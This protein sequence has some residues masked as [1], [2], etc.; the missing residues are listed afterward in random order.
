MEWILGEAK[1]KPLGIVIGVLIALFLMWKYRAIFAPIPESPEE[2][3]DDEITSSFDPK[4]REMLLKRLGDFEA[5]GAP[6]PLVTLEEFFEGNNDYGSI[7]YNLSLENVPVT[8][9]KLFRAIRER[10][11]VETVLV[12]VKDHENPDEWPSTDT[13][14]VITSATPDDVETWLSK[15]WAQDEILEGFDLSEGPMEPYEIPQGMRAI[16]LWWD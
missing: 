1:L 8:F 7:G 11:D 4:R 6:R 12:E 9:Y 10:P 5:P 3:Q 13:V 15:D 14:W 2:T 16:G